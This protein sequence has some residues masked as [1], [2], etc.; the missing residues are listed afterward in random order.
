MSLTSQSFRHKFLRLACMLSTTVAYKWRTHRFMFMT[1]P[2]KTNQPFPVWFAVRLQYQTGRFTKTL[3]VWFLNFPS[4]TQILYFS[5]REVGQLPLSVSVLPLDLRLR[6]SYYLSLTNQLSNKIATEI[7]V[8]ERAYENWTHDVGVSPTW[9]ICPHING[10]NV[11]PTG[12]D[13]LL[14]GDYH[15]RNYTIKACGACSGLP[16]SSVLLCFIHTVHGEL[17][18]VTSSTSQ[19]LSSL[20]F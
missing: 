15:I 7:S 14:L 18:A 1:N 9:T 16:Y 20:G 3:S 19:S 6:S 10:T 2:R 13:A 5:K 17:V 11:V 4:Q 8:L 12:K